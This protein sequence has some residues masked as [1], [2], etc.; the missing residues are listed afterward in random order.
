[1]SR[2]L[3]R[4][5]GALQ[6]KLL[7]LAAL[8]EEQVVTAV[9]SVEKKDAAAA[10]KVV[11]SDRTV[12][13]LEIEIEE[14]CLKLLAL[15]QPVAVDLRFIVAVLKINSDLERVADL[16]VNIADKA[17][18]LAAAIDFSLDLPHL[19]SM[20]DKAVLMLRQCLDALFKMDVRVAQTV[21]ASDDE[22]DD[23]NR[24]VVGIVREK[25]RENTDRVTEYLLLVSVSKNLERIAD[26]ATNIAEDVIYMVGGDIVRHGAGKG[27]SEPPG[28]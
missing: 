28:R 6:K 11:D 18:L 13:L 9:G 17:I 14:D 15:Y 8:A 23:L 26:H 5:I 4:E 16:A 1:M 3:Q 20:R 2:H 12:D 7:S 21:C 24:Q 19:S 10:K 22:V 27:V 25:I